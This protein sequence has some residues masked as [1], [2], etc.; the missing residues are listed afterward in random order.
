[1][2]NDSADLERV[3][4]EVSYTATDRS[5]ETIVVDAAFV[6][7][8]VGDLFDRL[9]VRS[10]SALAARVRGVPVPTEA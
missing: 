6:E 10:R 7:K 5:G 2:V 4:D 1:M 8:H 3:L 9:Q